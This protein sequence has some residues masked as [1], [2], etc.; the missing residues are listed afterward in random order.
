MPTLDLE[1]SIGRPPLPRALLLMA[2]LF[3]LALSPG[4]TAFAV[5]PPPDG[6]YPSNNTA[7]G[8][9]A[10][11]SL[12]SGINNTAIGFNALYTNTSGNSNTAVGDQALY[13]NTT[14]FAN[15]AIGDL[16]RSS[17]IGAAR[18]RPPVSVRS[19][20]T[21]PGSGTQLT[22]MPRL[23]KTPPAAETRP[24]GPTRS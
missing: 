3:I 21:P 15:T 4:W 17:A 18:T 22:V 6:G 2:L 20:T 1:K 14:A 13:S 16:W 7:E 12:T 5:L 8:E 23:V 19:K 9:D 10:L 24:V 11:F